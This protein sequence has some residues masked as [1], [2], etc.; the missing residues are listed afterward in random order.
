[1]NNLINWNNRYNSRGYNIWG[2]DRRG[3]N[4]IGRDNSGFDREGKDRDGFNIDGKK[5]N[6]W[7]GSKT[8]RDL[9][10]RDGSLLDREGFREDGYNIWG[11]DRMGYNRDG[12]TFDGYSR[13]GYDRSHR[14][15]AGL[16]R[17]GYDENGNRQNLRRIYCYGEDHS[18]IRNRRSNY[19]GNSSDSEFSYPGP[20][21]GSSEHS[22]SSESDSC[23]SDNSGDE[24]EGEILTLNNKNSKLVLDFNIIGGENYKLT[25]IPVCNAD[26]KYPDGKAYQVHNLFNK[27]KKLFMH[28]YYSLGDKFFEPMTVNS[29]DLFIEIQR[30]FNAKLYSILVTL[31]GYAIKIS[32]LIKAFRKLLSKLYDL[33][34]KPKSQ[35]GSESYCH[36]NR[37]FFLEAICD[38]TKVPPIPLPLLKIWDLYLRYIRNLCLLNDE[39]FTDIIIDYALSNV[40]AYRNDVDRDTSLS[41]LNR[42]IDR[43][44]GDSCDKG[45]IERLILCTNDF[46]KKQQLLNGNILELF[47]GSTMYSCVEYL[48]KD[49]KKTE[50]KEKTGKKELN[51]DEIDFLPLIA[52]FKLSQE[53]N[54]IV[55]DL[56]TKRRILKN[57]LY[58]FILE[59]LNKVYEIKDT[60]PIRNNIDKYVDHSIYEDD[61]NDKEGKYKKKYLKYKNKYLNLKK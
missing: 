53:N 38:Y 4:E 12:R 47:K 50:K 7:D 30:L 35:W 43:E 19:W 9:Y 28:L 61:F 5:Y 11:Y 2:R 29:I 15:R 57:K 40:E 23:E 59:R 44:E 37:A 39:L 27:E 36:Q 3:F 45:W 14:N 1:M 42:L 46:I 33:L 55:G 17:Y 31:P 6:E 20:S 10:D 52:E 49:L 56:E 34:I 54:S 21:S 26:V 58:C 25:P 8:R 22:D 24:R 16:D 13:R 48:I 18:R 32:I 60:F 41:T 51:I